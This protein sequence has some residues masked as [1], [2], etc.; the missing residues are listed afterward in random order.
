MKANL[1]KKKSLRFVF[2]LVLDDAAA[3]ATNIA[4]EE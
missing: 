3:V 1:R 2:I 4:D